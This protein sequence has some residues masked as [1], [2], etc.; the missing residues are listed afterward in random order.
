MIMKKN[1]NKLLLVLVFTA[2]GNLWGQINN[3]AVVYINS[4]D[5][6]PAN[7]VDIRKSNE[8]FSVVRTGLLNN[9]NL[10]SD[11][12][13]NYNV[14]LIRVGT[15]E[16]VDQISNG[17]YLGKQYVYTVFLGHGVWDEEAK[18]LTGDFL[19]V[20]DAYRPEEVF[21]YTAFFGGVFYC[22]WQGELSAMGLYDQDQLAQWALESIE[23][24]YVSCE[25]RIHA[26]WGIY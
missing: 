23:F 24:L 15:R 8:L 22:G 5:P 19:I 14:D 11:F 20:D 1:L 2:A 13:S 9:P 6:T 3:I 7:P 4:N 16:Q 26:A 10:P 18:R 25:R 21:T 12:A 17:Y